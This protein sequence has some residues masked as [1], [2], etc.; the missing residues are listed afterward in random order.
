VQS[1]IR[2]H[3]GLDTDNRRIQ[4]AERGIAEMMVDLYLNFSKPLLQTTLFQWHTMLTGGRRDLKDYG[5]YRSHNEPMQVVSG[6]LHNPKVH[7]EAPPSKDVKKEMDDFISWFARTAPDGEDQLPALT[8]AGVAHLYFVSIHPF[9]DGNGRIGRAIAEK[10]LSQCFG[11]PTLIAL[12]QI[13]QS[14][15]K[16][17]YD[18][19]ERNNKDTEITNWLI[20]FAKTVMD[21]H[22]YTQNIIDFLIEKTKLYDRVRGLLN[23]RQEKAIERMFR[24]GLAGFKGG[25]SAEKYINITKTS[26]ATATRDLQDLVEKG[27]LIKTGELKGTRYY[28]NIRQ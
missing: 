11:Q 25:L 21:A 2:R 6:P 4:S 16:A 9:E 1:S 7:F 17:Y 19:L 3:L 13:I 8:R 23:D 27:M 28:L 10:A 15:R 26:R 12:S 24:E 5:S 20:Y 18:A 14:N 22:D